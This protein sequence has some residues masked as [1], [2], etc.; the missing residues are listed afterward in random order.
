MEPDILF[1]NQQLKAEINN[2]QKR[3]SQ[4][5]AEMRECVE[6]IRIL[7]YELYNVYERIKDLESR[8]THL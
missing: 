8:L 2:L 5:L 3:E 6:V 4:R 1:T 7:K